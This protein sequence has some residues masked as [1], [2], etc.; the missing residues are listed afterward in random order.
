MGVINNQTEPLR[1]SSAGA[2][3]AAIVLFLP[4]I[5]SIDELVFDAIPQ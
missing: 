4:Q 2:D 1:L 3:K 5:T